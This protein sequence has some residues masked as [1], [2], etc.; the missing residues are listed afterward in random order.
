M[1]HLELGD[2][3]L[4]EVKA[5]A[6]PEQ[7]SLRQ[8]ALVERLKHVL[9]LQIPDW[10]TQPGRGWPIECGFNST[11]DTKTKRLEDG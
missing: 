7:Q 2:H 9:P 10:A 8:V 11:R 4:L 3:G 5:R 6:L 1:N